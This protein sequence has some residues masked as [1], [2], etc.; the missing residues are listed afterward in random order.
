MQLTNNQYQEIADCFPRQRGNVSM[1][2][3][4]VLNA[5][6]YVTEND[7]KWRRLPSYFDN[8]HTIYTRTSR[9]DKAGVLALVFTKLQQIHILAVKI[10]ILSLDST[11]IKIHPYG[12]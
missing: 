9:W 7:C 3:L 4:P 6:L 5:L 10:E 2:N 11:S 1:D 12:N 8:W